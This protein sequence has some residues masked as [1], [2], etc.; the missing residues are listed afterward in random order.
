MAE[1]AKQFISYTSQNVF[2]TGKAGT[3]KTT[4]LKQLA[5]TTT[6]NIIIAAPTGVAAIN[7]GG[8]TLHSLFQLPFNP[9]IPDVRFSST[10]NLH[11]VYKNELLQNIRLNKDKMNLLQE[12]DLLVIDEISMVRADVLDA[13]D[14]I[15]RHVRNKPGKPFGGVQVL[16]IGDLFQLS[17]I[18]R[19]EEWQ[20]LGEYYTSPFFFQSRVVK[21]HMPIVIELKHIYRQNEPEFIRVLNNV[22]NNEVT[23]NDIQLLNNC[24]DPH[25][26]QADL[27]NYITL[28]THNHQ[29]DKIN[30]SKLDELPGESA[31]F[32]ADVTGI[33]EE[34]TYPIDKTIT[35]KLGTQIMF[36][37]NDKGEQRRYFNGKIGKVTKLQDDKVW[38]AFGEEEEFVIEQESWT[39]VEYQYDA[40]EEKVKEVIIGEF[41][42]LPIRLAWAITIHKSQGL[43]FEHAI[44][45]V[46][47]SFATGQVYVA[48]SRV[49]SLKGLRLISPIN[50]NSIVSN[51]EVLAFIRSANRQE[52][53]LLEQL[54]HL[55]QRYILEQ[56]S[57][58]FSWTKIIKVLT[59][60]KE[61]FRKWK[62]SDDAIARKWLQEILTAS[63][64]QEE[65]AVKFQLQ[66][67][68]LFYDGVNNDATQ[69]QNRIKAASAYFTK[70]VENVF[71][72]LVADHLAKIK[73]GKYPKGYTASLSHIRKQYDGKMLALKHAAAIASE[74][75][76][77]S[78]AV[79]VL[80]QLE[81]AKK[82][83]TKV[84]APEP[85]PKEEKI[86]GASS[87]ATF[88]L[89]MEGKSINDI[90]EE[91]N[92]AVSTIEGHLAD[93]VKTGTI[94]VFRLVPKEK[95]AAIQESL[96][97]YD[98]SMSMVKEKLGERYSYFEIRVVMNHTH[99][100]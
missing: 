23:H 55:Q 41:K 75:H 31:S 74:L 90:A 5:A 47:N 27:D 48:L 36:I 10:H 32:N 87:I 86:K 66:L 8:V 37:K 61:S 35:L 45:D 60:H 26:S 17:P 33:F 65:T 71:L 70:E 62:V 96:Q 6:K 79:A 93:C 44:I 64:K 28:T 54:C 81:D 19:N 18:V 2:L 7:A 4:F 80:R 53:L 97:Q 14:A 3:G 98:N 88:N 58:I 82:E 40:T 13:I 57:N 69:L 59:A 50:F 94:S 52:A 39:N 42:Q 67:E 92:L 84:A 85:R 73:E 83:V 9:Y 68:Q 77:D 91:R 100:A 29:A 56:L 63:M 46:A 38:V 51:N 22:R 11:C 99:R 30:Q 34:R 25:I 24:Y 43:T 15:L 95:V 12:M 76:K 72:P 1:L 20:A 21:E 78:D 49:K 16:F 89:F